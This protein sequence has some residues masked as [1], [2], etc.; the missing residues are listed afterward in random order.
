MKV[1][2]G[3]RCAAVSGPGPGRWWGRWV[4]LMTAALSHHLPI[5][6]W[7]VPFCIDLPEFSLS[8]L[9]TS[10]ISVEF[11]SDP[12]VMKRVPHLLGFWRCHQLAKETQEVT[13][14]LLWPPL[15]QL[16]EPQC[17]PCVLPR[18]LSTDTLPT[19]A[20]APPA[21]PALSGVLHNDSLGPLD[22]LWVGHLLLPTPFKA[23]LIFDLARDPPRSLFLGVLP[24]SC[25]LP[26]ST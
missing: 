20:S 19:D 26:H 18:G 4:P 24:E 11:F 13:G 1:E 3:G 9:A 6:Y 14:L 2:V 7:I 22:S 5:F 8:I 17:P 15:P 23:K 10:G 25:F 12:E 16:P 21:A